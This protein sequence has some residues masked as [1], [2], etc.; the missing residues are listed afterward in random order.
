MRFH[1]VSGSAARRR[2][3][4]AIVGMHENGALTAPRRNSTRRSGGRLA[5]LAR[6]GDL[7]GRA[8]ETS[9]LDVDGGPCQRV[10]VVG[11]G[12]KGALEPPSSTRRRCR[13]RHTRWSQ[14]RARCGQLPLARGRHRDRRL[15]P[16]RGWP[17]RP[18]AM[19]CTVSRDPQHARPD[20][21]CACELLASLSMT[22]VSRPTLHRGLAPWRGDR[23]RH[24]ADAR[25]RQ[26]AGQRLHAVVPRARSARQLAREHRAIRTQVLD[27]RELRR[28]KMGSFLSVTTGT[29]EPAQADRA[30]ATAGGAQGRRRRSC[31]SARAS[32]ST[33]AASRSSSRPAWTR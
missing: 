14:R 2:T 8:G 21:A 6:R 23:R 7:R 17:P 25:P 27:E 10:L 29:E 15:L 13:R 4:C 22:G 24:R 33:A 18:W 28:L 3:D 11:L 5:R 19:R 20:G 16:R 1:A 9:L 32:P 30:C 31:S 12:R 26:P